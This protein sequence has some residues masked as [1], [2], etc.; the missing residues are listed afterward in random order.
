MRTQFL[1]NDKN[2][3]TICVSMEQLEKWCVKH[4]PQEIYPNMKENDFLQ[5]ISRH[6]GQVFRCEL[7]L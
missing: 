1:F 3:E 4:Y 7:G 2:N 6:Y 5:I